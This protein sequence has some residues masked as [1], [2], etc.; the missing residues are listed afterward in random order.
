M[1]VFIDTKLWDYRLDQ[2][3]PDKRERICQWLAE[4][5]SQYEMVITDS[6]WCSMP[7]NA[8]FKSR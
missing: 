5:T 4:V 6:I 8:P 1:R 2:R 3:E 7:T